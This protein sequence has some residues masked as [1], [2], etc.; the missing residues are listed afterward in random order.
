MGLVMPT[1]QRE[2]GIIATVGAVLV[3]LVACGLFGVVQRNAAPVV[4]QSEIM[5]GLQEQGTASAV[6]E[7]SV[8]GSNVT[9]RTT[10]APGEK[11]LAQ[12][13]AGYILSHWTAVTTV[14]V[15]DRLGGYFD[16]YS[17]R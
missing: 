12:G 7:A 16:L 15:Y 11:Y 2:W 17:R 8:S 10:L 4:S 6:T 1:E 9:L 14:E 5:S 13:F 3:L